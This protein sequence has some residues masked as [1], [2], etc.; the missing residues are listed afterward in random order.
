MSA[1]ALNDRGGYTLDSRELVG[2]T[3]WLTIRRELR[4]LCC[5]GS[6]GGCDVRVCRTKR[7]CPVTWARWFVD[8]QLGR[9]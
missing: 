6:E 4:S 3:A 1:Y 8:D 2:S 5:A 7:W 9:V